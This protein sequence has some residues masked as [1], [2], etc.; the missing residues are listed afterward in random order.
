MY[1]TPDTITSGY[2]DS[3][4]IAMMGNLCF[5][6]MLATI[7][8]YS[9]LDLERIIHVGMRDV[10]NEIERQHVEE[11]GI[12]VIWGNPRV[13][14]NFN[15]HLA[16]MIDEKKLES[17]PSLVHIDL[18]SF[19]TSIGKA[20][21][22]AAPGGLQEADMRECLVTLAEKTVPMSM[23]IASFDPSFEGADAIADAVVRCVSVFVDSLVAKWKILDTQG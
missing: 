16:A 1:Y 18:D 13:K 20:N 17:Q 4:A 7:P 21:R 23:T 6:S 22:F 9:P 2:F 5:K 19:D 11:A 8:G 14:V 3:M 10:L 15:K 12:S